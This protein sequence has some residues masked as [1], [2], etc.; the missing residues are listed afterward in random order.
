MKEVNELGEKERENTVWGLEPPGSGLIW[1]L[2]QRGARL[3]NPS[4]L[5]PGQEARSSNMI[6]HADF[7][8]RLSVLPS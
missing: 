4:Q 8:S 3:Y 1:T 2:Y 7:S 5:L 6:F